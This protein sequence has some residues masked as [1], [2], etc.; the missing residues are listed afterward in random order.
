MGPAAQ[1]TA[2][3]AAEAHP[4]QTNAMC[5]Y[6]QIYV[7]SLK[8]GRLLDVLAGHEGPVS[9]LAFS[10]ITSLLASGSWDRTVRTWDVYGGGGGGG[11][12]GDVLDHRHDVLAL[13]MRPDGRQL[14]AATLDGSIYLWDPVEGVLEGTIEGRRDIRGGRLQG[15]RRTADNSSAGASFNSLAY[16]ADGALL[17]AGGN[18]KCVAV[19]VCVAG[20][21]QVAV[22]TGALSGVECWVSGVGVRAGLRAEGPRGCAIVVLLSPPSTLRPPPRPTS[23]A[24]VCVCVRCE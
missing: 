24:Q 21:R 9:A 4:T 22:S 13:A 17:L 16:S 12:A 11:S 20:G 15:D 2:R 23:P 18:S 14:A 3:L 7:W 5:V 1:P 6:V 19:R 8:T 10:P